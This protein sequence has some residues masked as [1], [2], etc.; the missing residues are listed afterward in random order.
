MRWKLE[1]VEGEFQRK[2]LCAGSCIKPAEAYSH[3]QNLV[4]STIRDLHRIFQKAMYKTNALYVLWDH[5]MELMS[6]VRSHTVLDHHRLGGDT[7]TTKLTGD[8][9]DISHLCEFGWFN[10]VWYIDVTDPLQN[11]KLARYLGPSHDIG[12]AMCSKL[13]MEKGQIIAQTSVIPLSS[14]EI[15][16][17]VIKQQ[18]IYYENTFKT[19]LG[20]RAAGI[21]PDLDPYEIE[22]REYVPYQDDTMVEV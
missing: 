21:P 7:P 20:D 2:L 22:E 15:N 18:T 5:C 10:P 4:E 14:A 11:K 8:A 9:S 6:E 1:S 16:N 12:Q 13:I 17:A 3:N 19:A